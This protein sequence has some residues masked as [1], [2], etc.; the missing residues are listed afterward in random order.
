[1]RVAENFL[2]FFNMMGI[3]ICICFVFLFQ[4]RPL[5]NASMDTLEDIVRN[6]D[7]L[8]CISNRVFGGILKQLN[9]SVD[10]GNDTDALELHPPDKVMIYVIIF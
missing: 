4:G 5:L 10:F 7:V 9:C 1:M 2:F 6:A 3:S 8:K